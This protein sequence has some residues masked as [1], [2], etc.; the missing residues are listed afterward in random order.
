MGRG[1]CVAV[2]LRPIIGPTRRRRCWGLAMALP[3]CLALAATAAGQASSPTPTPQPLW[4]AYPLEA[5][6][7]GSPAAPAQG[8]QPS[9]P[10]ATHVRAARPVPVPKPGSGPGAVQ[11]LL[12]AA[13]GGVLG[14]V[15]AWLL[16][17]ATRRPWRRSPA[18]AIPPPAQLAL[19]HGQRGGIGPRGR[20]PAVHEA[21][22]RAKLPQ[23][24]ARHRDDLRPGRQPRVDPCPT[25]EIS[26]SSSAGGAVFRAIAG[27]PQDRPRVIA[28]SRRFRWLAPGPP[29][30]TQVARSAHGELVL[31]LKGAG[32]QPCGHGDGW[33]AER[34]YLPVATAKPERK[35][36][37][38]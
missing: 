3:L 28:Q 20:Q 15:L 1:R 10:K 4:D 11:A 2:D 21:S 19:P 16:W 12:A 17:P 14:F 37:D 34:L 13:V 27:E 24:P 8:G 18:A 29:P 5:S 9:V 7:R 32:W 23:V 6:S 38:W 26:W 31:R 36:L 25:C 30:P 22:D 33:Y 35:A